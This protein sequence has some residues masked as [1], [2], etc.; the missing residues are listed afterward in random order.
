MTKKLYYENAYQTEATAKVVKIDGKRV[1]LDKTIFFP[2]GGG[3]VGDIGSINK[4]SVIDTQ[5]VTS[6][7]TKTLFHKDFPVIQ[8]N[9]DVAHI[10]AEDNFSLD[11]DQT[12]SLKIDWERRYN[13]MRMHSAAHIAYHF[14]F[15]VF[16]DM[17]VKGCL[18]NDNSSRFDFS[19]PGNAKLERNL[20]DEVEKLSN[21]FISNNYDIFNEPLED[22]PEALYWRCH[23]IKI[24]CG[25][26]HVKN[27]SEIGRI[28]LKRK[29]QGKKIDRMYISFA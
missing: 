26:I 2:E 7:N 25:G 1:F 28:I 10:M 19:L 18:I 12:V 8:I 9:S 21:E 15:I 24:P 17:F 4:F 22:E 3:Q 20:L 5:K 14:A 23:D 13:I 29:S 11:V 27:T 16:G 6:S